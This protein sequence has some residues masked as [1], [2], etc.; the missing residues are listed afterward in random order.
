LTSPSEQVALEILHQAAENEIDTR[1]FY[2]E[3]AE[4]VKDPRGQE[5][6]RFLADEEALH[7][8]IVQMQIDALTGGRGWVTA[9][10]VKP[11]P[12][13]DLQ[14]LF[15]TPREQLRQQIRPDDRQL[16]ALIIALGV[17]DNS[18]KIYRQ[19]LDNTDDPVGR[20]VLK[21]LAR[22]EENHF[23]LVMQNYEAL[24]YQQHWQ[25]LSETQG[26]ME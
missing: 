25:G 13:G 22:A 21:H 26:G 18:Y 24:L 23:D 11:G 7:L 15:R 9:P 19:A 3:A 14:T 17:E 2:L 12:L 8:R 6:Y 5:M 10:E 20:Q 4:N 1:R 16:D